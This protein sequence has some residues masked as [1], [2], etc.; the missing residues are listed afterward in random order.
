[1]QTFVSLIDKKTD[2]CDFGM[3]RIVSLEQNTKRPNTLTL[4]DNLPH[5][6][7]LD[8]DSKNAKKLIAWLITKL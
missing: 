8:I 7:I 6:T 4:L 1:M 5:G 2:P 3:Y